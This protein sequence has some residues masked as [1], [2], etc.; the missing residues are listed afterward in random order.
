MN[1][2]DVN[3]GKQNHETMKEYMKRALI[4]SNI[5]LEWIYGS[6]PKHT[7]SKKQFLDLLNYCRETYKDNFEASELD[8][9]TQYV[10][11][12]KSG[13]SDLRCT[14]KGLQSIKEYCK[15]NNLTNVTN[16][17]YIKK[18]FYK[19]PKNKELKYNTIIN[20]DYNFRVN[21]KNEIKMDPKDREVVEF[22]DN[23]SKS[24]KHYRYKKRFSFID[25]NGLFRIDLT[26]VKTNPYNPKKKTYDLYKSL[27]SSNI[28]NS[29]E[30]YECEVEYIGAHK[31]KGQF[32]LDRYSNNIVSDSS[33]SE[34][35]YQKQLALT[36]FNNDSSFSP[37]DNVN[38][39]DEECY[40]DTGELSDDYYGSTEAY[41]YEKE[42][43]PT[44]NTPWAKAAAIKGDPMNELI[45]MNFW[46]DKSW[47]FWGIIDNKR[48]LYFD[49]VLE[50][51]TDSWAP[52]VLHSKEED[53]KN[54]VVYEINPPLTIEDFEKIGE[55][56]KGYEKHMKTF[57]NRF[58]VPFK[59]IMGLDG[60]VPINYQDKEDN[61]EQDEKLKKYKYDNILIDLVNQ[62]FNQLAMIL[63]RIINS[64]DIL[65]SLRKKNEII[66]HYQLINELDGK[67]HFIGPQP[68]S[69]NL[70]CLD[71]ENPDTILKSY[72]VT[73]KA[74]GI[75][76]ELII[77][78]TGM[79]YIITQ[80][81][82]VIH[83]GL[84][85]GKYKNCILDGEYI[86]TDKNG[87]SIRLY[88]CFDIYHFEMMGDSTI[89]NNIYTYPWSST[90]NNM[91]RSE[92]IAFF[93][94][95]MEY[96]PIELNKIKDGV[97]YHK[98]SKEKNKIDMDDCIRIGFKNYYDGPKVLKKDKKDPNKYINQNS[99]LK[100]NKKL[101]DIINKDGY[102]YSTDGLI[103]L[104]M[105]KPVK[106]Y[107][108]IPVSNIS[109]TWE[110]NYK[111]KPPEENTIDFKVRYVKEIVNDKK[112]D[113][114]TSYTHKRK[115]YQCKQFRL[116]VAYN[117]A[118]D[119]DRD[120]TWEILDDSGRRRREIV[121]SPPNESDS[122]HLCNIPL[123]KDKI[124]C[125]KDKSE[126]IDG[127][128]Y[129]MRYDK[130]KPIGSQWVPLRERTDKTKPQYFQVAN[131]IWDTIMNPVTENIII[132]K[133][134][135]EIKKDNEIKSNSYYVQSNDIHNDTSLRQFHNFVK[136]ILIDLCFS[137]GKKEISIMDTSIGRG[138]DIKKYLRKENYRSKVKFLFGLDISSDINRAAHRL[139][140]E[141]MDK[142]KCMF[143]QYDTNKNIE[144]GEGLIGDNIER[145]RS[146]LDILYDRKKKLSPEL[147]KLVPKYKGLAKSGFDCIFSQFS[148]HYYFKS[149]LSLRTYIQN[150]SDN[151]KKDGYFIGTCY[152]G[153]T[154]NE[155]LESSTNQSI[156]AIDDYG[157]KIY[158]IRM[159]DKVDPDFN[160]YSKDRK[161]IYFGKEIKVYMNSIGQELPE[162]LVNFELFIDIMSEYGF[163]P[164]LP[165]GSSK[166]SNNHKILKDSEIVEGVGHFNVMF[167][168]LEKIY[169]SSS[170]MKLYYSESINLLKPE[171]K[172]L[173]F[174]SSLN[175]WFIFKK[176]K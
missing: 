15:S 103:F 78:N 121:F 56:G 124:M 117:E 30:I 20:S 10:K 32:P 170:S 108:D 85:F 3:H 49:G 132:G 48:K 57:Q 104:P 74:D 135:P 152:D 147:R 155:I 130:T 99:M 84:K 116:F 19:D 156:E 163:V 128:I 114:L 73:E 14:I 43:K 63:L 11:L 91:C 173:K 58:S 28:L 60:S 154:V 67:T 162:Y 119:E 131:N 102:E 97:Y 172:S 136:D 89:P 112:V 54:Y 127:G 174:L 176:I 111:W 64:R 105:Y 92:A 95:N 101:L 80:K 40:I 148:I 68:V 45:N 75:R 65:I 33:I 157:N 71:P 139:Y 122:I 167:D 115:T 44:M 160:K 82:D 98:W 110:I 27:L 83:T 144:N 47:L 109:G 138:G 9:K 120:Y 12:K 24:H 129:E 125:I 145:N 134:K 126:I 61:I 76:G 175:N 165:T 5:E 18:G 141:H 140:L 2:F 100:V 7:L 70:K 142:P 81:L 6:H 36:S 69:M 13:L 62:E 143:I 25:I 41:D 159:E 59:Y 53:E 4:A 166:T 38:Y 50:N 107:N 86:T 93:K 79:G 29:K 158:S 77:D 39:D 51:H 87:N 169:D 23:I 137:L 161:D 133:D 88:M 16:V 1:T 37:N 168:S 66:E 46:T 149:E 90:K 34:E 22:R 113:K 8:I 26:I 146:L 96:E 55:K 171:N 21:L 164:E 153:V 94:K 151:C 17:E 31:Y 72:V 150:L 35:D 42:T 118:E 106:S 52:W 123:Q